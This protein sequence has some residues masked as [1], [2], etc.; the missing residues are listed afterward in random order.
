MSSEITV[1]LKDEKRTM[2]HKF[3]IY[4]AYA[5]EQCDPVISNCIEEAK[6]DFSGD[7]ETIEV[8]A[9]MVLK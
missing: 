5:F 4:E 9:S 7:V 3:L 1:V 8:K 2:R 6:K